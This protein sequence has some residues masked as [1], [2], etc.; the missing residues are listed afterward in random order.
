MHLFNAQ[1]VGVGR[2]A[3]ILLNKAVAVLASLAQSI[4][5]LTASY[6]RLNSH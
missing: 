4:A 6:L 5:L 1:N 2:H 3:L